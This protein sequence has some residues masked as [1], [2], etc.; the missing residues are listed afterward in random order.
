MPNGGYLK[1][2][3]EVSTHCLHALVSE[4]AKLARYVLRTCFVYFNPLNAVFI[5]QTWKC[6]GYCLN[7]IGT[8]RKS[9]DTAAK[10]LKVIDAI[11]MSLKVIDTI[12]KSMNVID[13]VWKPVKMIHAVWNV[14][15]DVLELSV[16][17]LSSFWHF[18]IIQPFELFFK[19]I[20]V[21]AIFESHWKFL[22]LLENH[23]KLLILFESQL[24]PLESH[25]TLLILF[26]SRWKLLILFE[27]LCTEG[28]IRIKCQFNSYTSI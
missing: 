12:S 22:I 26:K 19:K 14:R 2:T 25:W 28:C 21:K 3:I 18:I 23:W 7:I 17:N 27:M 8:V 9:F 16:K 24:I 11:W 13:T 15:K 10:P 1:K 20:S 6:Y 5:F 4:L